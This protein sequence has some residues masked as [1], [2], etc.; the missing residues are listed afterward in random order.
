MKDVVKDPLLDATFIGAVFDDMSEIQNPIIFVYKYTEDNRCTVHRPVKRTV[1][2]N[3]VIGGHRGYISST[4]KAY[5]IVGFKQCTR[6]S[7]TTH[8]FCSKCATS[9]LKRMPK[10]IFYCS[11]CHAIYTWFKRKY[12]ASYIPRCPN[13]HQCRICDIA[14][15]HTID[16]CMK[17]STQFMCTGCYIFQRTTAICDMY[18]SQ[19]DSLVSTLPLP[20]FIYIVEL[21]IGRDETFSGLSIADTRVAVRYMIYKIRDRKTEVDIRKALWRSSTRV[22]TFVNYWWSNNME[23]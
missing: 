5:E 3:R 4:I 16:P 11:I 12:I 18:C 7:M 2:R 1:Y 13:K 10:N 8:D 22:V 9:I 14:I 20:I 15:R 17:T 23:R 19:Q 21:S 6:Q